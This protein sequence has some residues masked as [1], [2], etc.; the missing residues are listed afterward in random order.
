MLS[1]DATQ[2]P[3]PELA[4]AIERRIAQRTWGRIR[5][6][7]VEMTADRVVVHGFSSTYYVK[8]LALQAVREVASSAPLEVD[9]LVGAA[10]A[11]AAL[12]RDGH[13]AAT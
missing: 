6:L 2:T 7:H 5:Q 8:Q 12:G 11:G 3:G 1:E 13:R 9:I 10:D 4:Q